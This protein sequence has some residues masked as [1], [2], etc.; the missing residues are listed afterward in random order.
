MA[1]VPIGVALVVV[2]VAIGAYFFTRESNHLTK[3][4]STLL[5]AVDL[6][7]KG[8]PN[9]RIGARV[10][11]LINGIHFDDILQDSPHEIRPPSVVV[12]YDSNSAKCMQEFNKLRL[13]SMAERDLPARERLFISR[14]DT[15]SAPRRAWFKFTPEMDLEKRFQVKS[16]PEVVIAPPT[17]TGM[18]KWCSQGRDPKDPNIELVGCE[19]FEESCKDLVK[20][21][22]TVNLLSWLQTQIES[23]REPKII[24]HFGTYE[25]QGKWIRQREATSTDNI[26]RNIYLSQDFPAFSKR[27]FKA[28]PIPE[29]MNEKLMDFYYRRLPERKTEFWDAESTQ[30]NFH[31]HPTSFIDMDKEFKMKEDLANTYLKPLLEEWSGIKPL[32]LTSFYGLREYPEGIALKNHLDRIDTHVLSVTLSLRKYNQ[33]KNSE[34]WPLEVIDWNGDHVRYSHPAGTMVLYESAKLP[35]GRPYP[36]KEGIH[37]GAFCHFKP[38]LINEETTAKWENFVTKARQNQRS[39]SNTV[40]YRSTPSVQPSFPVFTVQDYGKE[41]VW[42]HDSTAS[43]RSPLE[44]NA[45]FLNTHD[46]VLDLFWVSDDNEHVHQGTLS[47]GSTMNLNSYLGHKFVWKDGVDAKPLFTSIIMKNAKTYSP[48]I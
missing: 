35:H 23:F 43:P 15:Y 13:D 8:L 20:W 37:L 25:R 22:G 11:D 24:P 19:N 16:C 3:E 31:E 36:N 45:Q 5:K 17:C 38:L 10:V 48:S 41:S 34:E 26:M 32:Q 21:D 30:I 42:R 47:P 27:G 1:R 44:T 33:S 9:V 7:Q 29:K 46:K 18:T 2:L 40:S 39:H 4:P 6:S 28:I 12:F 14:Y